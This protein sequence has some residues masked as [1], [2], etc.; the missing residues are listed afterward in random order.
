MHYCDKNIIDNKLHV[1]M[2]V[3]AIKTIPAIKHEHSTKQVPQEAR[4]QHPK[5]S[6]G[7]H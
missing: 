4:R 5:S 1:I 6:G 3:P 2:F 7:G